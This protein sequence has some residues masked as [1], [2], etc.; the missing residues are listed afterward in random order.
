MY[1]VC[2]L[3]CKRKGKCLFVCTEQIVRRHRNLLQMFT[4]RRQEGTEAD[5]A[6]METKTPGSEALLYCSVI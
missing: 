2:H 5:R 4:H 1:T 6:E 3:L